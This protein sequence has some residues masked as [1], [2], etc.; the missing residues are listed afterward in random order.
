MNQTAETSGDGERLYEYAISKRPDYAYLEVQ[1]PQ[2]KKLMV[3]GAA[4]ATMTTNIKMK[5]KM[6]VQTMIFLIW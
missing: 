4:M 5:T 1:I 3:E 2:S 6:N